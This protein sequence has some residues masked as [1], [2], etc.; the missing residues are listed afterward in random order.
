MLQ[1]GEVNEQALQRLAGNLTSEQRMA[2]DQALDNFDFAA[3]IALLEAEL[4]TA[5]TQG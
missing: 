5:S 1:R 3:A 2:L 4:S